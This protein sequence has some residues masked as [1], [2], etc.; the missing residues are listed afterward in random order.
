LSRFW[1]IRH[2]HNDLFLQQVGAVRR[3]VSDECEAN[4][5][6]DEDG[7]LMAITGLLNGRGIAVLCSVPL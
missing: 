7:A 4:R 5:F 2:D 6:A 1:V 3:W